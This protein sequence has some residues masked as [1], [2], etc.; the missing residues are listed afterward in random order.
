MKVYVNRSPKQGPWGGGA[1][2]INELVE[3]LESRG[4]QVY[5]SLL[6]VDDLDAIFCFDP[7]PNERGEWYQNFLQYKSINSE[8]K[9]KIIQRVGDLGTH[10]KPELTSL[11]KQ[12]I[13]ISDYIIF[14]SNWAAAW[15]E[16]E[17]ENY[18]VIDNAPMPEFY[19]FRNENLSISG[20][21]KLVTHHWSTNPKKGF[22]LYK[23]LE[24]H[25]KHTGEFEFSY[26]GRLPE[27]MRLVNHTPPI[28]VAELSKEL[29]KHDI[30][31]TAS[32]EEAGANHV[33]EAMASGLPVVY[34]SEGGSI[35]N[36]CDLYGI[37]FNDFSSMLR[38]IRDTVV[39][40]GLY[41]NEVL[42]YNNTNKKVVEKYID[43]IESTVGK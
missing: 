19:E 43:I 5:Y 8:A 29:P 11:V 22:E 39:C 30:Y 36:Y 41:K 40:Y 15:I 14:P 12:T 16:H 1:K 7:R 32:I 28:G 37:D 27:G 6:D 4:H 31:I 33:L 20:K 42:E 10:S 26:I 2:T 21:P 34:H 25:I 18:Q 13:N 17:K 24:E 3:S 23:Q 38:A 35:A 9:T